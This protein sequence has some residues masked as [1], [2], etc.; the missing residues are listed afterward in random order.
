M[1]SK[2]SLLEWVLGHP[3]HSVINGFHHHLWNGVTTL[4]YAQVCE[5]LIKK[6]SD[7]FDEMIEE[8]HLFHCILNDRISK[9]D[10]IKFINKI[11]NK[12]LIV[13]KID[14]FG[15]PID[16]TLASERLNWEYSKHRMSVEKA[17]RDLEKY[18]TK[19]GN[20]LE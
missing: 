3:P 19:E 17:L 16:R 2:L 10:L 20:Y 6:G 4:Q 8:N 15:P 1:N 9:Y 13:K 5:E 11:Y 18:T 14:D 7:N 12:D